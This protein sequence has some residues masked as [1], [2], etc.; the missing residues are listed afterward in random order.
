MVSFE[1][2]DASGY[3]SGFDVGGYGI[4][5]HGGYGFAQGDCTYQEE[6]GGY[7]FGYNDWFGNGTLG[8]P[9]ILLVRT[10]D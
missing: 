7:G 4:D 8:C 5:H 1:D 2:G 9:L 10:Y 3:E 6:G